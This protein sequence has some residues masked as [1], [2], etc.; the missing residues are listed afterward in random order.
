MLLLQ[1]GQT[2]GW[3][4]VQGIPEL[5]QVAALP[6]PERAV[7]AEWFRAQRCAAEMLSLACGHLRTMRTSLLDVAQR[8]ETPAED[9]LVVAADTGAN[10][11]DVG[12]GPRQVAASE[13]DA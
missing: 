5:Q 6:R 12:P 9:D 11:A 8:P 13:A 1:Q 4:G 3:C 10:S 7:L 2:G